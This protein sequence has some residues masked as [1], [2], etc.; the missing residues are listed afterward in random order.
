MMEQIVQ[1]LMMEQIVVDDGAEQIVEQIVVVD[2]G[3]DSGS[4]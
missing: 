2:D 1:W 4:G 3:A